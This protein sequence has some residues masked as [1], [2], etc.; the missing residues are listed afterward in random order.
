M[1]ISEYADKLIEQYKKPIIKDGVKR[2]RYSTIKRINLYKNDTFE[3]DACKDDIFWNLGTTRQPHFKKNLLTSLKDFYPEGRGEYNQFQSWVVKVRFRKWARDN[4]FIDD[5]DKI[6]DSITDYGEVVV[7]IQ[8]KEDDKDLGVCNLMN[9][10]FDRD[11]P[12]TFIEIHELTE[13]QVRAKEGA[14]E[15]IEEA[16][17]SVDNDKSGIEK[18]K[19]VEFEGWYKE[20]DTWEFLHKIYTGTGDK[21]VVVFEESADKDRPKYRHFKLND[22]CIGLFERLFKIQEVAN[23]RVNQ[24]DES[25]TI[26]SLLLLKSQAPGSSGNVLTDAVSGMIINDPTL[27]QVG[28]DNRSLSAFINEMAMIEAQADKLCMTPEVITGADIPSGT[29]FRGLAALTNRATSAFKSPRKRKASFILEILTKEIF[30][31]VVKG[32]ANQ[33]IEI[34]D[35]DNDIREFDK[36]V[37]KYKLNVWRDE[38]FKKDEVIQPEEEQEFIQNIIEEHDDNGRKLFIKKGFFNWDFGFIYNPSNEVEDRAQ[39]N[40]VMNNLLLMKMQNPAIA[41]DPLFRQLAE[42][43]GVNAVKIS[44]EEIQQLQ[45]QPVMAGSPQ[46]GQKQDKLM[47]AIDSNV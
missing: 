6:D 11:N 26:A 23:R 39:Q 41:N 31:H 28:I 17:E 21:E 10:Y 27:E 45:E 44:R 1:K 16:I 3:D 22:D 24:N 33:F 5:V 37:I 46:I 9:T 30:P 13:A 20:N 14:W 15:N 34:A 38:K 7:K 32:W 4:G 47:G 19:F 2:D 8:S 40:D 43:N 42:K 25:Q 35:D 29:P 36:R 18:I 12:D